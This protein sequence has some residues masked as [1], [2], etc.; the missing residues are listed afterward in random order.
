[1][2]KLCIFDLDGTVLDTVETIA[3][4]ANA[5][6][7]KNGIAPIPVFEYKK[8]AGMG[9]VNLIKNMLNYRECYSEELFDRVFRDY[10]EAYNKDTAYK[11]K[12]FDGLKEVLDKLKENG[13]KLA[14]VSNK[15]DYAAKDVVNLIYGKDY[16][17]F[18]AGQRE[19]IALKPSPDA[20]VSVIEDM[21]VSKSECVYIGDTSVDMKTGKNTNVFTVGV[22]WGFREEAELVESG[23][24]AIAKTPKDLYEIIMSADKQ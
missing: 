4:Y 8:L 19:G 5:S 10:D 21:G 17:T 14:I 24:D 11:S 6:L 23:A 13:I 9:I 1:M 3:Y 7:E 15:P 20:V 2:I 22:L 18:V 12:I 16:F